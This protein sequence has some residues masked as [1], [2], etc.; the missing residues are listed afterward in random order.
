MVG[1]R[2]C[3][4]YR[5]EIPKQ[6][7]GDLVVYAHGFRGATPT[8]TV[9]NLPVRETA[10]R[11][12]F[13]W[14]ASSYRANG[15]NPHDG[16]ADTLLLVDEFKRKVG[17]PKRIFIY[18]SSMGGF[19]VVDAL[20]RHPDIYAGGVSECGFMGPEQID[21]IFSVNLLADYLAG[22]DMLAPANKGWKGQRNLLDR[23]VY[24]KL[25][26]PP[27][28]TFDESRLFGEFL[29]APQ[30]AL[31]KQGEA[32]R[33]SEILLSG[34]HRPFAYEGFAAA[35][36]LIFET[37]RALYALQPKGAVA[38]G[39]NLGQN[40]EIEPGFAVNPAQ[41]NAGVRR[42]EADPAERALFT[43][44]GKLRAP[45][46]TIQDTGDLFVP[47]LNTQAY[48]RL[49]DSAGAGNLLVERA[50]RRFLHC[51]FTQSER[52]RAFHDLIDWVKM[53]HKPKGED[54]S[55][56]LQDAGREWTEPLRP[57]D[58]GRQ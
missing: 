27:D 21:Y 15:F 51:D 43:F 39:T 53:G 55:G 49:A 8:L 3:S 50:V 41:L 31:R 28:F 58:P 48:R 7:N 57:D 1:E 37:T 17:S 36:K 22:V 6:W 20:E 18:G 14:A 29:S 42:V 2:A 46:L 38:A 54:L 26:A 19:V 33:N 45:L 56:S 32:L 12:G 5:I 4:G 11:Q 47:M 34:G 16:I 24:P 30:I 44:T 9:T 13:A 10:I 40:Y 35:Y 25:G 23:Y 52:D